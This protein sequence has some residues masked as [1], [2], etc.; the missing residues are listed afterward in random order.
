MISPDKGHVIFYFLFI[1]SIDIHRRIA[2]GEQSQ[3]SKVLT[4]KLG[5]TTTLECMIGETESEFTILWKSDEKVLFQLISN[6][7]LVNREGKFNSVIKEDKSVSLLH[8][9]N[10]TFEDAGKYDCVVGFHSAGKSRHYSWILVVHGPPRINSSPASGEPIAVECC[11]EVA[12]AIKRSDMG[13]VW[14]IDTEII[15]YETFPGELGTT[16]VTIDTL[17]S[18]ISVNYNDFH[19]V[20]QPQCLVQNPSRNDVIDPSRN[21]VRVVPYYYNT[22]HELK[23]RLAAWSVSPISSSTQVSPTSTSESNFHSTAIL[24]VGLAIIL[25][26]I[27]TR[28]RKKHILCCHH[29]QQNFSVRDDDNAIYTDMSQGVPEGYHYRPDT[30]KLHDSIPELYSFSQD[31]ALGTENHGFNNGIGCKAVQND[32]RESPRRPRA[33]LTVNT[34]NSD[35]VYGNLFRTTKIFEIV[36]NPKEKNEVDGIEE[37]EDDDKESDQ[38]DNYIQVT[39]LK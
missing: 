17:C 18:N 28:I 19:H 8:I 12:F 30:T 9:T 35:A 24:C 36:K 31:L 10:I 32:Y 23:G 27:I 2:A 11:V 26:L 3:T 4:L 38:E 39:R 25:T 6:K 37:E 13:I 16:S 15:H 20:Q 29:R 14:R 5:N 34:E 7:L 22:T 33:D 1:S 21:D